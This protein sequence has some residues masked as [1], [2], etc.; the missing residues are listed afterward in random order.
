VELEV[1]WGLYYKTL[2]ICNSQ[3]IDKFCNKLASSVVSH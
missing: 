2:R 3:K 1:S